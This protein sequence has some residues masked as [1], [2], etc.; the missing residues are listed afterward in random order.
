MIYWFSATGNSRHVGLRLSE[1]LGDIRLEITHDTNITKGTKTILVFPCFFWG[2]PQI[3]KELLQK[4]KW[5]QEDKVYCVVTCGGFLGTTANRITEIIKPAKALVYEIPMETNYLVYHE[6]EEEEVIIRKLKDADRKI[7]AIA[8]EIREGNSS[9]RSNPLLAPVGKVVSLLYENQRKTE[10]FYATDQCI[11]CGLC[12][13]DCPDQAIQLQDSRP[14][15]TKQRCQHCLRCL[16]YCPVEAIEYGKSTVGKKR[17]TYEKFSE[18][19]TPKEPDS[20]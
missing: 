20:L 16:H 13:R 1:L 19:D 11:G 15:W 2:V 14:V 8:E 4:T 5:E 9:Y 12:E 17:Y 3:V 10:S 7:E 6:I 18:L